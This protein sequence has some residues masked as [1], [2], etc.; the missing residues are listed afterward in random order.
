M[1][2]YIFFFFCAKS[3]LDYWALHKYSCLLLGAFFG[4]DVGI[5]L[6]QLLGIDQFLNMQVI[7]FLR[8]ASLLYRKPISPDCLPTQF[9]HRY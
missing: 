3:I 7:L 8:G 9:V 6:T 1:A 2:P 5:Q 4:D